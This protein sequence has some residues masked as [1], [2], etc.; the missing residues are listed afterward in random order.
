MAIPDGYISGS[1]QGESQTHFDATVNCP[2]PE[3]STEGTIATSVEGIP[4]TFQFRSDFTHS[5]IVLRSGSLRLISILYLQVHVSDGTNQ[6]TDCSVHISG[7]RLSDSRWSGSITLVCPDGPT[8]HIGGIF[9]GSLNAN[10]NAVCAVT[11]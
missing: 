11:F 6:Y 10:R 4:V 5:G 3:G 1:F 2:G 7:T 9:S 8:L